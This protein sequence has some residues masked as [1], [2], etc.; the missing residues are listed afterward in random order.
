MWAIVLGFIL[1]VLSPLLI[2]HGSELAKSGIGVMTGQL[3]THQADPQKPFEL[4]MG[5]ITVECTGDQLSSG[6]NVTRYIYLGFDYPI[7]VRL[8]EGK[9]LVSV[10]VR[11]ATGQT[12]AKIKDNMWVVNNNPTIARDRNYNDYAFEVI[13]SNNIPVLQV[14]SQEANQIYICGLFQVPNLPPNSFGLLMTPETFTNSP[15]K[16]QIKE[17]LKPIFKYPSAGSPYSIPVV[18]LGAILGGFGV[19]LVPWGFEIR[20][21]R[22]PRVA[23]RKSSKHA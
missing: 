10:E 8:D 12:V 20:K 9:L 7:E 3:Q 14:Y 6:L 16:N 23:K 5:G 17:E 11:D 15:T 22:R 4:H 18:V 2:W 13:D 19:V 1:V 21:V